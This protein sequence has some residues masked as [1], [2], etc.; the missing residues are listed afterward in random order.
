M[1]KR[2]WKIELRARPRSDGLE[3]LGQAVKLVIDREVL[4][5]ETQ[6]DNSDEGSRL[7]MHASIGALQELDA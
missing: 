3:R 5:R 6:T 1:A 4:A 2:T 7:G